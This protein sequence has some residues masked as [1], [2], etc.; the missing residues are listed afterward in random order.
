LSF[1]G[2]PQSGMTVEVLAQAEAKI[3]RLLASLG[4]TEAKGSK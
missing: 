3:A 2:V 4:V 1:R